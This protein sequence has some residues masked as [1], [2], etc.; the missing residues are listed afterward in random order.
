[1]GVSAREHAVRE[2]DVGR[3]AERYVSA[4][5][6]SAGGAAVQDELLGDVAHAAAD[7]GID[8][9]SP[10]AAAIAQR[11]AEVELVE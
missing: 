6:R 9:D 11:L 5:E 1:M 2:H 7:V 10:D 4:I 8:A 3:A